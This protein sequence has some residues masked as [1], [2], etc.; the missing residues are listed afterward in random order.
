MRYAGFWLRLRANLVDTIVNF[1]L[2]VLGWPGFL[3]RSASIWA[4][5]PAFIVGASYT[6]VMNAC[7]GQTLGKMAARIRIV[8]VSGAPISWREALLRDSVSIALG[9]ISTAAHVVALL[10]VPE[11]KW[12]R[13]WTQQAQL[14]RAANPTW[15][16]AATTVVAVWFWGELFVLLFNRKRRALHDF[17]AGTVVV[18]MT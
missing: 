5:I 4:A 6:V 15:G 9:V 17:I 16:H 13:N 1:P 11:S 10:H 2:I 18:R 8:R 14:V 3:P 7:W 12:S